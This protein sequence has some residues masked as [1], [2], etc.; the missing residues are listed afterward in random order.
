MYYENLKPRK[1]LTNSTEVKSESVDGSGT[2]IDIGRSG[3][4][5]GMHGRHGGSYEEMDGHPGC[6]DRIDFVFAKRRI[7]SKRVDN[8]KYTPDP[9]EINELGSNE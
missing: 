5:L 8:I 4:L 9:E 3:L 7:K 1:R 6:I 2:R